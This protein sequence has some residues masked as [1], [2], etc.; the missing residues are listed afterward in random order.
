MTTVSGDY[1]RHPLTH[2]FQQSLKKRIWDFLKFLFGHRPAGCFS[3]VRLPAAHCSFEFCPNLAVGVVQTWCTC[4]IGFRSGLKAGQS[5]TEA[6]RVDNSC[7]VSLCRCGGA[8]SCMKI[9]LRPAV[10]LR[11]G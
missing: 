11:A 7:M 5:I 4:S 3:S 6:N 2:G 1:A 10:V 9:M 8:L